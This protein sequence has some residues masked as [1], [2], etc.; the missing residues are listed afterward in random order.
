MKV[1]MPGIFDNDVRNSAKC[2]REGG[3]ILYP[4]DTI[5][6]LGCDPTDPIAV[7][8]VFRIKKRLESKSLIILVDGP[9]MIERYVKE[10]PSAAFNLIS[11][12]DSPL[13]IIYPEGKNLADGVYNDDGSIGIRICN[14]PFCK[15]LISAFRK[16]L[17]STSANVSGFNPPG[18]YSK[19]DDSIK[20]QVDYIVRYR[21]DD[22]QKSSPSPVIRIDKN[23]TIKILRM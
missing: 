13:T 16:P 7:Q 17:I 20:L 6:G 4:T 1:T 11:V 8:K 3:V 5:W 14:E 18:N 2:L 22:R 19:I 15:A 12:S 9:E 23:G 10:I 21:Q